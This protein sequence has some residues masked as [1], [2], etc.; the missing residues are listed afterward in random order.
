MRDFMR[1]NIES[2]PLM[3]LRAA[4]FLVLGGIDHASCSRHRGAL[5]DI[6]RRGPWCPLATARSFTF[7]QFN[8]GGQEDDVACANCTRS[9]AVG[10][11]H[12]RSAHG[13]ASAATQE[14]GVACY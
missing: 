8:A 3:V 12:T 11:N 7:E 6:H 13:S 14:T 4:V 9:D 2:L 1:S 10:A 5:A